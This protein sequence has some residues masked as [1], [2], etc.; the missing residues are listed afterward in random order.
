LQGFRSRC[1]VLAKQ[2][3]DLATVS[4]VPFPAPLPARKT[5]ATVTAEK[6]VRSVTV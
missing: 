2:S 1:N 5:R 3:V 4:P 6:P